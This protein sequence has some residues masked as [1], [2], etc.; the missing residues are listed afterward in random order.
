MLKDITNTQKYRPRHKKASKNESEDKKQFAT[1]ESTGV[2][3][4]IAQSI[5]SADSKEGIPHC[6]T[7]S[8]QNSK[9]G[10][11]QSIKKQV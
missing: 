6:W 4:K 2:F 3:I 9:G 8:E 10:W 1:K 7:F 5:D 11:S